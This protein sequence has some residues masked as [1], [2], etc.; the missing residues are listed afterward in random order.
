MGGLWYYGHTRYEAGLAAGEVRLEAVLAKQAQIA[1]R[2][3]TLALEA[4]KREGAAS[5]ALAEKGRLRA[6]AEATR[7][8]RLLEE[9]K[10]ASPECAGWAS[11]PVLCPL[12]GV[13]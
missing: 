6:S 7:Y 11:Q 8:R 2:A 10:A 13:P 1:A 5:L 9:A 4:I 12:P 3:R